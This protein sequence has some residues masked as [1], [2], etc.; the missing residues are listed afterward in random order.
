V[1]VT[2]QEIRDAVWQLNA[3]AAV[4]LCTRLMGR[5]VGDEARRATGY[6]HPWW[7]NA[8]RH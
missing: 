4:P 2:I 6:D 7:Y 5:D 3:V 8:R 1:S